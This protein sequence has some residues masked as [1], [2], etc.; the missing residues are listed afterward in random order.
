MKPVTDHVIDMGAD[1]VNPPLD[2]D[3]SFEGKWSLDSIASFLRISNTYVHETADTSII[4]DSWIA[5]LTA[6]LQVLREQ[7]Q[8]T[9]D[10]QGTLNAQAYSFQRPASTSMTSVYNGP[11]Q[12]PNR[13]HQT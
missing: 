5:A 11:D 7:S 12:P 6:I 2:P 13:K 1:V 3:L 4:D 10:E 8:P 9:F